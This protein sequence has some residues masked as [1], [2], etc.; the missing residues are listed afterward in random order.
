M[1]SAR[2][3]AFGFTRPQSSLKSARNNLEGAQQHPDVVSDYLHSEVLMGRMVGLFSPRAI[4]HV[5]TSRFGVI[6]KGH[7]GKWRLIV[8]LSHP[9][10]YSVNDRISKPLCYVTID[11][12]IKEIMRLV[13]GALLAKIDIK[14]A[15]CLLPE[16]PADRH[17]LG[18][19]WNNCVYI[20][21]CFPFGL[22]SAPKLFNLLAD[23]L[24]WIAGQ[25]GC[26]FLHYQGS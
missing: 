11:D 22:R 6:Q 4:P 12:A 1:E 21:A 23:I 17:M 13:L 24:A 15:F 19:R 2:D 14:N 18:M 26:R 3:S 16:H 20:D 5:H 9:K 25:N 8:D 7:T 10:D